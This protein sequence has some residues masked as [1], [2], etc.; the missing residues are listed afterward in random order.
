MKRH[1][2]HTRRRALLPE[3]VAVNLVQP[4]NGDH[5]PG[6]TLRL[7]IPES[8][9]LT[10]DARVY[11]EPYVRSSSMR[12]DF[13]MLGMLAPPEETALDEIDTGLVMFRVKVVDESGALGLILASADSVRPREANDGDSRRSILPLRHRD[14]GNQ[15]WLVEFSSGEGPE[16][17]LNN[18]I[19]GLRERLLSE[20]LLQGMVFPAAFRQ[21]LLT[22]FGE[23]Q[24]SEEEWSADW[25]SF[26]EGLGLEAPAVD[27]RM[28]P[29]ELE[30][31]VDAA[32]KAFCDHKRF[33]DLARELLEGG[34]HE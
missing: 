13:G 10:P 7:E 15:I 33:G 20:P 24:F 32:V 28:E 34:N 2:N 22:A 21:V 14:L 11:V 31:F 8:W 1:L 23:G 3:H 19:P 17:V 4:A 25:R 29:E 30:D 26:C 27:A 5:A 6:F 16:L 12:F 9:H 18:R